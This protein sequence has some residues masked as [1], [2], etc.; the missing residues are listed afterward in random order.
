[1]D[2]TSSVPI[3]AALQVQIEAMV[4]DFLDAKIRA[5]MSEKE[6]FRRI[7]ETLWEAKSAGSLSDA[8]FQDQ[9]D[10]CL[11]KFRTA[12]KSLRAFQLQINF[13]AEDLEEDIALKCLRLQ[14]TLDEELLEKAYN[15]IVLQRI[16]PLSPRYHGGF[17]T[18]KGSSA[19][20]RS[21][22]PS[23]PLVLKVSPF[24]MS[25]DE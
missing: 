11:S 13:L 3:P 9:I 14:M 16:T 20:W 19:M 6:S 5:L 4:S 2:Q 25:L 21:T 1:M 8:E 18:R 12:A 7:Q 10:P 24:A 17:S 22:T 15:D 23:R